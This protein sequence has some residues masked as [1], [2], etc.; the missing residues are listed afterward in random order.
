MNILFHFRQELGTCIVCKPLSVARAF[1]RGE[2][3]VV[4]LIGADAAGLIHLV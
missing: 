3:S 1:A 2:G 4:V